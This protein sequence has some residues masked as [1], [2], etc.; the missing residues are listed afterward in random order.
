MENNQLYH[1]GILGMKWGVRRYQNKDGTLTNAGKNRYNVD[2]ENAKT[3]LNNAR[4][5]YVNVVKDYNKKTYGGLIYN[6]KAIDN[7]LKARDKTEYYKEKLTS[8]KIKNKLNNETKK[9]SNRRLQLEERYKQKGFSKEDAEIAAYKR[10]RTEKIL[11]VAAGITVAT[12]TAYVAYKHYDNTVDK[13]I[14][15]GTVLQNISTNSNKGVSDAF[16][17]SFTKSDNA[18][19]RGLYGQ[20]LE[21]KGA[22]SI[23]ETKINVNKAMK[24]A[25][26]KSA[27][28]VLSELANGDKEYAKILKEHLSSSVGRYA[29]EKQNNVVEKGLRSLEKGKVNSNV[30]NA[31][32]LTLTDHE[33]STSSKVSS[34]LYEKLKSKGYDAIMDVNDKKFSGYKSSK[35]MIAFN[36][37]SKT[38]VKSIRK[39]SDDEIQKSAQ[40]AL[41]N[42]NLKTYAPQV[43]TTAAGIGLTT[44]G[45]NAK[46]KQIQGK[47]HDKIVNEYKKEHPNTHL[48]YNE[49]LKNYYDT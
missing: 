39:V 42:I 8:E 27:T 21:Q 7:T 24:V 28:K 22:R 13:V 38:A 30:Y 9:K 15:Q 35:P 11:A 48:S 33:L 10:V 29:S 46:K 4:K 36:G 14:K 40:K 37:A 47:K 34:G 6:K 16:Y 19:Y 5:N 32:N 41:T 49:I 25:S 3:D 44:A 20:Q 17:F 23:Y 1:H 12:A 45:S 2:I 43:A 26:N 31:L 18:K